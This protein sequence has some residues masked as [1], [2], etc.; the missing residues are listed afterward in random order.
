MDEF[1]NVLP[2]AS[3]KRKIKAYI[4][5]KI[6]SLKALHLKPVQTFSINSEK[7]EKSKGSI[8]D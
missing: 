1:L 4:A 3:L 7:L 8:C 5:M 6:H 2:S